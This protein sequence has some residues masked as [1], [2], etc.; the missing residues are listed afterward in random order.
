MD[1][2]FHVAVCP[3]CGQAHDIVVTEVGEVDQ[4]VELLA[5]WATTK[6]GTTKCSVGDNNLSIR[7]VLD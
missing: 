6:V 1:G 3:A 7:V 4:A 2:T 5:G